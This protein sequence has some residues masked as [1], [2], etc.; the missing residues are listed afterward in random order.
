MKLLSRREAWRVRA[1]VVADGKEKA[2]TWTQTGECRTTGRF[3]APRR[4]YQSRQVTLDEDLSVPECQL[5]SSFYCKWRVLFYQKAWPLK[6]PAF[7]SG[8]VVKN[9]C[10]SAGEARD[11]GLIPRSARSPAVGNSNPL[12]YSCLENSIDRGAWRATVHGVAELDTAERSAHPH[13]N[14][15]TF[16]F[17]A[18]Q[19]IFYIGNAGSHSIEAARDNYRATVSDASWNYS[20]YISQP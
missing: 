3:L 13:L 20:S 16:C 9:L 1:M 6:F 5:L 2:G 11:E 19:G 10:A 7:P 15:F 12:Q 8:A 4:S 18:Q 17:V 14:P